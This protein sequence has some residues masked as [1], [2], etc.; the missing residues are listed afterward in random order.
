MQELSKE[1]RLAMLPGA[2]AAWI[3]PG[4]N[5]ELYT[6]SQPERLVGQGAIYFNCICKAMFSFQ[7]KKKK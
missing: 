6:L 4:P 3:Q 7:E 2:P 5:R 1:L